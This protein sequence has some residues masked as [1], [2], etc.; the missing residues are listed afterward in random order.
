MPA[1]VQTAKENQQPPARTHFGQRHELSTIPERPRTGGN[2]ATEIASPGHDFSRIAVHPTS[3]TVARPQEAPEVNDFGTLQILPIGAPGARGQFHADIPTLDGAD[4]D[5][6][7]QPL[8]GGPAA[9]AAAPAAGD[10]CG[11]PISMNKLTSGTFLGG[12]TMNSYFPDLA[13]SGTFLHP[14]TAGTFDTGRRAGA[15][16]QLFGVI[17]SPCR[18]DLFHLEQT[19]TRTRFRHNGV[20]LAD[21]GR[22]FDDVAK[23][24]RDASRP[25]FR[26]EFLGGGTAPLGFII[27]MADPPNTGYTATSNIEHDRDFVTSLV[28][29]SGRQSVSWSLSTRISGGAVTRNVLT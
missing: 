27:S 17:S 26:Q 15:N 6:V 10:S 24:G 21:E 22:T 23:S 16:V 13:G 28:G 2:Q 14:G 3:P 11:Q 25:P 9:G 5:I 8:L 1:F 19:V 12:L 20:V 7:D 18:P 29:P 4:G